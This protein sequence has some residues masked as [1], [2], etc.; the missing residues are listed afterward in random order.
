MGNGGEIIH[1]YID[2]FYFSW[3][4]V[5]RPYIHAAHLTNGWKS[6]SNVCW[7]ETISYLLNVGKMGSEHVYCT[8]HPM[9][10]RQF[11][12][13]SSQLLQSIF[14]RRLQYYC[15][16]TFFL[17][18]FFSFFAVLHVC[19]ISFYNF[20]GL[21]VTKSLTGKGGKNCLI[22]SY[23]KGLIV[24]FCAPFTHLCPR[25]PCAYVHW[26]PQFF[27][28][29]SLLAHYFVFCCYSCC[30]ILLGLCHKFSKGQSSLFFKWWFCLFHWLAYCNDK[31]NVHKSIIII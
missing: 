3:K 13:C 9:H 6:T 26:L 1:V 30:R 12:R 28:S 19:S 5:F 31:N 21:A 4:I 27:A 17:N 14:Q 18:V 7:M 24:L 11:F 10:Y 16:N 29:S 23:T 15:K 22:F 8:Q 25:M 20:F 2:I